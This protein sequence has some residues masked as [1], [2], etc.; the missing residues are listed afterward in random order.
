MMSSDDFY[1]WL[2]DGYHW[3]MIGGVF[4]DGLFML[5]ID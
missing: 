1:G 2:I 4:T 3:F 5:D